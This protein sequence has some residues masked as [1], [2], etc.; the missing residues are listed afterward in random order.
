MYWPAAMAATDQVRAENPI[1]T[2]AKNDVL[3]WY[4]AVQYGTAQ[5]RQLAIQHDNVREGLQAALT[6]PVPKSEQHVVVIQQN[7]G[8][9][10]TSILRDG[11]EQQ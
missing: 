4:F 3:Y 10:N 9:C 1:K 8:P 5:A 7:R 2:H 6:L 11:E